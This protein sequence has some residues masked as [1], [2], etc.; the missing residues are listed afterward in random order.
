[1]HTR[2]LTC[3]TLDVD[4]FGTTPEAVR[5]QLEAANIE[6][7]PLWKPMHMQPVFAGCECVG[8]DVAEDLFRRG[9]CLP[10]GSGLTDAQIDRVSDIVRTGAVAG[11]PR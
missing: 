9:L 1:M 8:G 3:L 7:R 10:S 11:T 5:L 2:W 6:A 4:V